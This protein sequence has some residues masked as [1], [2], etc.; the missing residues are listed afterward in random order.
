MDQFKI[1][2]LFT[3]S[4]TLAADLF[5]TRR[6][7]WE[8]IPSISDYIISRGMTLSAAQYARPAE[9]VWIA[10]SARVASSATVESPCIIDENAEIR[11]GA[12]I[13]GS[14]IV[15]AGAV[16]GNS[17]E[18]KNCILFDG[19][20]VPHFNYVGD[21]ILGYKSHMGAGSITSNVKSD[22]SDVTLRIGE[23]RIPTGMRKFGAILGDSVEI[24]CNC[25]LNP[26]T[27]VGR[28]TTVYPLTAL[29][30]VIPADHI[31]KSGIDIVPKHPKS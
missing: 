21:S 24:G 13:R 2:N 16:V 10:K 22:R 5:I 31:V 17:C 12:Y 30:G 20:Q 25:V 14:A 19:V 26:G 27:V 1:E 28:N 11:T 3:L 23:K 18:L 8:L 6:Y 15:G 7:P 4:H 29:R 9:N